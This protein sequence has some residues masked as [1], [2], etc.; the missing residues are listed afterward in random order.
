MDARMIVVANR[1]PV[2][3]VEDAWRTSPGG[4]VSSL[5]PILR[6]RDGRW[7]GWTGAPD[8]PAG[9]FEHEGIEQY[10]IALDEAD[11]EGYYL[12]FSN[13][14]IWPLYHDAIRAPE[15][16]RT[17]WR[18]YRDVNRRFAAA[19]AAVADPGDFVWVQDYHLQLVPG[20][21]RETAPGLKI[22][23]YLHIPFPPVEIYSR[24]PWRRQVLDGILG[25]DLVGFQ[26]E[27]AVRNFCRAA[28]LIAGARVEGDE[29]HHGG[30]VT[31]VL[32][33]PISIDVEDFES[34]ASSP[35]TGERVRKL[36]ADLHEPARVVLGVDRLDYTKGID[37]RLRAFEALLE[38]HP[39][40]ADD[41]VFVQVAVP[42]R[43][44]L[45]DYEEIRRSVEEIVGRINGAHGRPHRMP[46]HYLYGGLDRDDLVTY[47]RAADVMCITPLRDGMNLVAKEYVV[48]RPD[49]DGVL[50]LSEFAGAA[51]EFGEALLVNPYD[52]DGMATILHRAITLPPDEQRRRMGPLQ[53]RVRSEDVHFWAARF[54]D[55]M[56]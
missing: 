31:R 51:N 34:R 40:R 29:I 54:L 33:A 35:E 24:M 36:R 20:F 11:I 49:R 56:P 23:F 25:S 8:D 30:G 1:L 41:T 15:F 42:S 39:E 55:A 9:P 46:V 12:G 43:E 18:T 53:D 6:E 4:L 26:T 7:I 37:V 47:Y 21:L 2:R 22:G 10:P 44:A 50:V 28:A 27:L 3:R 52:I 14:T 38:Q 45:G 19:A 32:R 17:W 48:S 13:A 5:T 16:H